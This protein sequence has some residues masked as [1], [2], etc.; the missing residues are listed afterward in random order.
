VRGQR[1]GKNTLTTFILIFL[2]ALIS[3]YLVLP[4]D[5]PEE[6]TRILLFW[7]PQSARTLEF[8]RG[9]DLQGGLQVLLAADVPEGQELPPGAMETAAQI[10]EN[11]V[12][13][14]GLTE[15]VVQVRGQ[16]KIIVE[17]PGIENPEQAIDTIRETALLEFAEPP[18]SVGVGGLMPG[19]TVSTTY[20]LPEEAA[21]DTTARYKT[22]MT[23]ADLK[24]VS[25]SMNQRTG[26]WIVQFKLNA[27]GADLFAEYTR[28][29][30]GQPLCII[31]D[32]EILSCPRIE[33]VIPGGEGM[34][35]G[36][37]TAEAAQKL[38]LQLR[39]GALPVPLR[40]ESYTAIGPSLGETSVEKSIRAGIVGLSVV[41]IFMLVYYRLNG[42]VAD[43]ALALYV[44]LN[45]LVYKLLPVT[46]TLPGIAGFLLSAGM[47]VDANILVF[48]RM[49]EE[50]RIGR[51]LRRGMEAGFK[52]AWTSVRDSNLATLLTC[53]ILWFFGDA[54]AAS[55]VKGFAI[56]L[57]IGTLINVFTAIV[58]TRTLVRVAFALLGEQADKH[59]W[60]LGI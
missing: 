3:L 31:L 46:M 26:Q 15:P 41:F 20:G 18:S 56:T 28:S 16:R 22:L 48:E 40:I 25:P 9:L 24:E 33:S 5:H 58:V 36:N 17:L 11:R 23:G 38:A 51:S 35:S 7:R 1:M 44:L 2:L 32:K 52:R 29:H 57:S 19:T 59:S 49:K 10:V 39:Y 37:F 55:L 53:A 30:L 42:A 12:N 54:F 6:L 43:L 45:L 47:A 60:L 13:A 50:L 8:R 4:I 14:L 34:I 27:E 21:T